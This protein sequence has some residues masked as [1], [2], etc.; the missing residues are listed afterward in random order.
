MRVNTMASGVVALIAAA[1]SV[2][3]AEGTAEIGVGGSEDYGTF[4]SDG[5]GRAVYLFT[6]DVQGE[7]DIK[8]QSNCYEECAKAWPP[9]L[10]EGEPEAGDGVDKSFLGTVKRK[11]GKMQVT[12][13]GWPL[14]YFVKD[15]GAGDVTGQ[16]K[17]GFGG[18]WYLIRPDGT[19]VGS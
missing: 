1:S 7:G 15:K 4:L 9:L 5:N 14:Y 13:D 17:H 6:A 12:Y 8:A 2:V 18:E 10:S 16:D 3:A 11:D 19:R